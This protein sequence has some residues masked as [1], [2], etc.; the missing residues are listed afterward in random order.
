MEAAG[1][2]SA[3]SMSRSESHGEEVVKHIVAA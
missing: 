1:H 2:G 3:I